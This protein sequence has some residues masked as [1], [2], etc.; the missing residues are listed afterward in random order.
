MFKKF[1]KQHTWLTIGMLKHPFES[2]HVAECFLLLQKTVVSRVIGGQAA[3]LRRPP[4][5]L[6][7]YVF[8]V[9]GVMGVMTQTA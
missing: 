2:L 9:M 7:L 1:I 5:V 6:Y 4:L 8:L 3:K